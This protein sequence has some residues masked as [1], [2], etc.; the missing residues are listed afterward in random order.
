MEQQQSILTAGVIVISL[1]QHFPV[2][3]Y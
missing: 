3:E 2:S 1:D